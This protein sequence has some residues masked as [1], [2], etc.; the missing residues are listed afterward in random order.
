MASLRERIILMLLEDKLVSQEQLSQALK[1]QKEKGG[2][3]SKILVKAGLIDEDKLFIN[4]SKV[5]L[6]PSIDINR[7]KIDPEV[8]KII[9]LDVCRQYQIIP[10]S[11]LGDTITLAMADPLNILALDDI[12][13]LTGYKINPIIADAR[14]FIQAIE[15]RYAE[16]SSKSVIEGL[17]QGMDKSEDIQ[18][19]E[20]K[21]EADI[22]IDELGRLSRQAPIVSFVNKTLEDAVN[23]KGSDILIEPQEAKLRIR[24]RIDGLLRTI[25]ENPMSMIPLVVSRIKVISGLDIA[26]HRL[27]QDG[28]FK[29]R[30]GEREVDFRVSLLP[31]SLGEKVAI[32]I[33]D[34]S[35]VK[36]DIDKLGFQEKTL[37]ALKKCTV[38]PYGMILVCGPTGS[39]KTTTLYSLIKLVDKPRVNIITVED[40]VEFQLPGINQVSVQSDIGLTFAAALRSIL[41]Q[42]PNAIMVGEIRDKETVDIAIKSALTGHLVFSTL[43]TTTA[44][45][46]VVRLVNMG[47]EPFLIC[48][49]VSCIVAQRLVRIL[50]PKCK[51]PYD[52]KD[53]LAEKLKLP[54][55]KNEPSL[56]YRPK[57]C[58]DCFKSGYLGRT[59]LTEVLVL[60]PKIKELIM[61]QAQEHIMKQ[62]ARQEGMQTLRED[63]MQKARQGITSL[64]EVL[65]V[66][67][68]DE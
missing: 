37:A 19:V 64:E 66:S 58:P 32:R 55:A 2:N 38:R 41:R 44:S 30:F 40:P 61:Q 52:M 31:T 28:R 3:L 8:L 48:S 47:I 7:F 24:F 35:Q 33:L 14:K 54:L 53:G 60:S 10:I 15:E 62:A 51:Q 50:C 36:L 49:A 65:R 12:K 6:K 22:S 26:E 9:P 46:A 23:R 67:A 29:M 11:K 25:G 27:P 20:E 13:S 4:M 59:L 5:F 34:K 39:G 56:F 42:D 43:H 18:L 63:G 1:T 68:P 21:K 57:G 16:I 17:I 45:G